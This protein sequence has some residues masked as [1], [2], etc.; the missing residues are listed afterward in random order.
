[1]VSSLSEILSDL[2]LRYTI[3]LVI[4]AYTYNELN[5]T[6][7]ASIPS[8]SFCSLLSV[9]LVSKSYLAYLLTWEPGYKS[10]QNSPVEL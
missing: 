10:H 2:L 8:V 7:E 5:L 3:I 9:S 1:M 4:E 6:V